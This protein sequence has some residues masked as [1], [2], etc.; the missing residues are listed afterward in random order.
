MRDPYYRMYRYK[1]IFRCIHLHDPVDYVF[2]AVDDVHAKVVVMQFS[3]MYD[4][5]HIWRYNKELQR[6]VPINEMEDVYVKKTK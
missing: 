4:I 5:L 3:Q 2:R 6:Y 1:I